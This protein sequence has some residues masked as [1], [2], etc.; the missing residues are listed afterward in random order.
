MSGAGRLSDRARIGVLA[1]AGE[2]LASRT[3]RMS[4]QDRGS[5]RKL[6]DH[7]SRACRKRSMSTSQYTNDLTP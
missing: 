2:V 5:P 4:P 3:V 7:A 1:G 6:V